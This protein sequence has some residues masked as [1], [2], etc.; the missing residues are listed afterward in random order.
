[1]IIRQDSRLLRGDAN[2]AEAAE[3]SD[4]DNDEVS[5]DASDN[6]A[7]DSCL[8]L[9]KLPPLP[10]DNDDAD[11]DDDDENKL[12]LIMAELSLFLRTSVKRDGRTIHV[13]LPPR[14]FSRFRHFRLMMG[15]SGALSGLYTFLTTLLS[16]LVSGVALKLTDFFFDG[17]TL[18]GVVGS[19]TAILTDFV[20]TTGLTSSCEA[21]VVTTAA[22][23]F[24]EL[25][26]T[27]DPA[28]DNVDAG[29]SADP[30]PAAAVE[31]LSLID[32]ELS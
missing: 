12:A 27:G 28:G 11:A 8:R 6:D 26:G 13:D 23:Q 18:G 1:M 21:A 2:D 7:A 30:L 19:S 4:D 24:S 3:A 15:T 31:W 17:A 10:A 29:D 5:D 14:P 9:D 20:F 16:S 22:S 25:L 32:C